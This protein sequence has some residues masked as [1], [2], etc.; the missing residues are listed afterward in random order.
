MDW[1]AQLVAKVEVGGERKGLAAVRLAGRTCAGNAQ[2]F[3]GRQA[4]E[5]PRPQRALRGSERATRMVQAVL[6]GVSKHFLLRFE[7]VPAD[8]DTGEGKE[9]LMDIVAALVPDREAATAMEPGVRTFDDPA[10]DAQAAAIRRSPPGQDRDD[11]LCQEAIAMGLGVVSS[12]ALEGIRA[13]AGLAAPAADGGQGR[14]VRIEFGDVVDIGRCYLSDE[15]DA[16]RVGNEVMLGGRLAAIGFV[17]SS[18][19]PP[20]TARTDELSTTVHRWSRR[21]RRRSSASSASCNRCQPPMRCHRHESAPAGASRAAAH[22][23][24]QLLPRDARAGDEQDAGQNGAVRNR[25]A[26]MPMPWPDAARWK[27]AGLTEPRS[28]RQS[29]Y[30]NMPDRTKPCDFIQ[31]GCQ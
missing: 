3:V 22:L 15:R 5:R 2:E 28:R 18:V 20:R 19:F 29:A 25:R 6:R 23:T 27:S 10:T 24:R 11:A 31:E 7:I 8:E 17:R 30:A 4:R 26:A 1:F 14:D 16:A 13:A 21:P 12:V 9:G